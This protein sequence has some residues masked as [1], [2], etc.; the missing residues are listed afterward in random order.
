LG[1]P[2]TEAD[3]NSVRVAI[4]ANPSLYGFTTI[5]NTG[6]G[7]S[8]T[9]PSGVKIAWA[10]LCS[11][12][13]SAPSIWAA[14]AENTHLFADDEHLGTAGEPPRQNGRMAAPRDQT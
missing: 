1:V 12:N 5:S 14:S 2:F 4:A 10:L 8:C 7:P 9:Q 13:T 6:S 3:V 11:S